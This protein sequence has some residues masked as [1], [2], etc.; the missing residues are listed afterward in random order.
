MRTPR[1]YKLRFKAMLETTDTA[2]LLLLPRK[3]RFTLAAQKEAN[4]E[5]GKA[6]IPTSQSAERILVL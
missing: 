5:T 3:T 4:T 6:Q 2:S 1:L